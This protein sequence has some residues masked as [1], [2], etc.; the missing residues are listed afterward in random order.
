METGRVAY[1]IDGELVPEQELLEKVRTILGTS[2]DRFEKET[3][4]EIVRFTEQKLT[5]RRPNIQRL[6]KIFAIGA[7]Q[8]KEYSQRKKQRIW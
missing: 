2:S 3:L 4:L 1:F 7:D 6:E 8:R 5:L